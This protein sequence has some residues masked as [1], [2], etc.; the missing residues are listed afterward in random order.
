[1]QE[2]FMTRIR[3]NKGWLDR[4]AAFVVARYNCHLRRREC[5]T[6]CRGHKEREAN[7]K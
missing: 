1:M 3:G 4:M 2:G 5:N 7:E 6:N